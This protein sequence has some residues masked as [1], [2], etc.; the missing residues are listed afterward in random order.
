MFYAK[1]PTRKLKCVND[2]G[3]TRKIHI[4]NP[5]TTATIV[6]FIFEPSLMVRTKETPLGGPQ[7]NEKENNWWKISSILVRSSEK[8]QKEF[9]RKR[10]KT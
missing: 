6:P 5:S 2:P 9:K 3:S 4:N 8:V 7:T 1:I 10:E